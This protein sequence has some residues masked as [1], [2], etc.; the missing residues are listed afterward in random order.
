M[1]ADKGNQGSPA[2][3]KDQKPSAK[4]MRTSKRSIKR[5]KFDDEL[6]ESSLQQASEAT[7]TR[8]RNEDFDRLFKMTSGWL[9]TDDLALILAVQQTNDLESVYAGVSFSSSF[10]LSDIQERWYALLYDPYVSRLAVEAIR[11]LHPEQIAE[12]ESKALWSKEEEKLLS[13][14]SCANLDMVKPFEELLEKH[15]GTFFRTRTPKSLYDHWLKMKHYRLLKDQKGTQNRRQNLAVFPPLRYKV[16]PMLHGDTLM[17]FSDAEEQLEKAEKDQ[18]QRKDQL[19]SAIVRDDAL[20]QDLNYIDRQQKRAIR[21]LEQDI[22]KWQT[23]VEGS[24]A[25]EF[26]SQT[27]AVLKGRIVRY[28]MRSQEITVGRST[29]SFSVDVDLSLEGPASKISRKQAVI[30]MKPDGEFLFFNE[31][32]RPVFIDGKPVLNGS[33]AKIRH[34]SVVEVGELAFTFLVNTDLV[35]SLCAKP[36]ANYV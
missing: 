9:P 22:P 6:V 5:R 12:I 19:H 14:I 4:P 2:P 3:K 7:G 21:R 32:K 27:F 16:Q 24:T 30:K 17:S 11:Q 25:Q 23:L 34:S 28:L 20:E 31:G 35:H 1:E 15:G 33:K 8:K 18:Q 29:D 13:E 10:T 26:D 36:A